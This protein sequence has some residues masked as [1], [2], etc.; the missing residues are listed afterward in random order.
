MTQTDKELLLKDLCSRL[1]Y[2]VKV[3]DIYYNSLEPAPIWLIDINAQNVRMFADEGYQSIEYIKPY[4]FPMSSMTE[5][6][7]EEF[8]TQ[9]LKLQLQVID[10]EI[11][12]EKAT[13]FEV[14]FYNKHHLDW[15]GLIPMGLAN[16][17]TGLNIY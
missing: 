6:Q 7:K 11:M 17:A 1:P 13:E 3:Q 16:D 2:G 12:Y 8:N 4:L 10:E 14:D 15:R 9:S 5:E